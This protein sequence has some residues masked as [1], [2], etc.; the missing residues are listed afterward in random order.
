MIPRG[1]IQRLRPNSGEFPTVQYLAQNP[2]LFAEDAWVWSDDGADAF[3][4]DSYELAD[5]KSRAL[6]AARPGEHSWPVVRAVERSRI[7]QRV[8]ASEAS[9]FSPSEPPPASLSTG[10]TAQVTRKG[11]PREDAAVAGGKSPPPKPPPPSQPGTAKVRGRGVARARTADDFRR[12]YERMER[13][14]EVYA[15]TAERMGERE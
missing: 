7:L 9:L 2:A 8:A 3:V 4:F 1:I 5:S 13:P 15:R 10:V 11:E 6:N 14:E 12:V